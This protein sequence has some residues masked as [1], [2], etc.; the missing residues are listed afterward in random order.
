MPLLFSLSRI[1]LKSLSC[2]VPCTGRELD[3]LSRDI[4]SDENDKGVYVFFTRD[5]ERVHLPPFLSEQKSLQFC[6]VD[7]SLGP[8]PM[9]VRRSITCSVMCDKKALKD[10]YV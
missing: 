8:D 4:F 3:R 7:I 6:S 1:T 2:P 5:R 9:H 10:T